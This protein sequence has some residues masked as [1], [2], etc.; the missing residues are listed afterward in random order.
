MSDE[1]KDLYEG[2]GCLLIMLGIALLFCIPALIRL[3]DRLA[4]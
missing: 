4:P 1:R 2:M 3:I